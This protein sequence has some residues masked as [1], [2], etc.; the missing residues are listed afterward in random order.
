MDWSVH[1]A[2]RRTHEIGIRMAV[3][4]EPGAV[5]RMV[6][7]HGMQLAAGG[8]LAGLVA[9]VAANNALRAAFANSPVADFGAVPG[10]ELRSTR[11]PSLPWSWSCCWRCTFRLAAP[12]GSIRY[13]Y[14]ANASPTL[15]ATADVSA[16]VMFDIAAT[17]IPR[18]R[19]VTT[20][21]TLTP[22]NSPSK[23]T[24]TPSNSP[25]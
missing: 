12:R 9:S 3:G 21:M 5:L 1:N 23:M 17:T 8:I 13:R 11:R 4:A 14:F 24:L 6:L 25:S 20:D 18:S 15:R 22:G 10:S 2:S 7:R 19:T 16:E